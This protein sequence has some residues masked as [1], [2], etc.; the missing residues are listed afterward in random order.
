MRSLTAITFD[1]WET[2]IHDP[3]EAEDAR[4]ELRS[5]AMARVLR[6]RGWPAE[7]E[8]LTKAYRAAL[9]EMEAI[10]AAHRDFDTPE[11]VTCVLRRLQPRLDGN[12]DPATLAELAR[13]Y[14]EAVLD[15]PPD[16]IPDV[17]AVLADVAARGL[18][19]GLVCNTGRTPG[20]AL[21]ELFERFGILHRFEVLAFS[22]EEGIRKPDPEIFRR[23]LGRL[24]A[25]PASAAHV[26]D[27]ATSDVLGAKRAGMRAVLIRASGQG[28]PP[29]AP[30]AH[31]LN[32][33]ELPGILDEWERGQPDGLWPEGQE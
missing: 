32:L 27:D 3:V 8:A 11:Q 7:P 6:Q 23:T 17:P 28:E 10:W 13:V 20:W 1:V 22:N 24:G 30:D 31:I 16:L 12:P 25:T 14:A 19:V 21:R 4:V 5:G 26:G 2:L 29:V 9:P 18:R 33:G 15:R